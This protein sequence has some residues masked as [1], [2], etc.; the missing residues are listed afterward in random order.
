MVE[1]LRR[2][3]GA[4]RRPWPAPQEA[5]PAPRPLPPVRPLQAKHVQGARLFANR[6][7][8]VIGLGLPKG[9][10]IAE[11]GVAEGNFSVFLLNELRP[12]RFTAF[13]LFDLH[14]T[15]PKLNEIFAGKTHRD[16][17]AGRLA[18]FA[19]RV[20]IDIVAGD[21]SRE[22][23]ALGDRA[24][25]MIYIDGDHRPEGVRKDAE[26]AI[27][28]LNEGGILIFN[29]YIMHDHIANMAYGVVEVVNDLC[30]DHGWRIEG[31][32]LQHQM[33]CDIALRRSR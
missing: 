19:D 11:I 26:A 31:Y 6:H 33:F 15:A 4:W 13:D 18:P 23:M 1:R 29:D 12:A 5:A 17:Y 7:D 28:R 25:D 9:A 16:F 30:I 32:A 3:V 2:M 8:M 24:F 14:E 10:D 21:S 22:L 27:A 20:E